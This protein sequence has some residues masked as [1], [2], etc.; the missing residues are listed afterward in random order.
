VNKWHVLFKE[1]REIPDLPWRGLR[2]T[3]YP[4]APQMQRPDLRHPLVESQT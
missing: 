3:G 1:R 2:G 4:E